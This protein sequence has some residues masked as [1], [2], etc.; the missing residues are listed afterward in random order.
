MEYANFMFAI[1]DKGLWQDLLTTRLTM[2]HLISAD[3][4]ICH[5]EAANE[6]VAV[7]TWAAD[8]QHKLV[9]LY[10]DNESAVHIFQAGRGRNHFLQSCAHHLWL[11][12]ASHDITLAVSHIPGE[13]LTSSADAL[14]QWHTGQ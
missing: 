6:V 8:F 5:L 11:I 7:K 12:C 9:H 1:F 10:C 3:H 4:P 14:S 13:F 2:Y